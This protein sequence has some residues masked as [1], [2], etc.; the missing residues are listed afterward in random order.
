MSDVP[1]GYLV[2]VG[3]MAWCTAHCLWVPRRRGPLAT[4][5]YLS[6]ML[7][8]EVPAWGIAWLFASTVLALTQGDLGSTGGLLGLALAVLTTAGLVV[9]LRRSYLARPALDRAL[10][11]TLGES[12]R[13]E[14]DA[15][16]AQGLRTATPKLRPHL[17]PFRRRRRGVEHLRDLPYGDH[18]LHRLD[19]YRPPP[20][21]GRDAMPVLVHLHGG[22]FD[23][24]RKDRESLPLLYRFASRGWLCVSANYR[25]GA[26]A[27][28]PDHLVDLKRVLAWVRTHGQAYGADPQVVVVSGDSAGA[29][30]AITAAMTADDPAYQPGFED[31]DTSVIAAVGLYGYYGR[32]DGARPESSPAGHLR[33]DTPPVLLIHGDHDSS[34]PVAWARDFADALKTASDGPVVYAELPGAQHTF[35]LLHSVRARVTVDRIEAFTAWV[36]SRENIQPG[37][38]E[39]RRR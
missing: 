8:N 10:A 22:T 25:I 11:A 30:L 26:T 19:L 29:H 2:T 1:V 37:A 34:V 6:S 38:R 27:S 32:I 33:P 7:L 35:D 28:F 3:L 15:G 4:V 12:W 9:V 39:R 23:S 17:A 21:H 13:D 5:N 16:L 36:R 18:P 31:A 20:G 14:I 24:G